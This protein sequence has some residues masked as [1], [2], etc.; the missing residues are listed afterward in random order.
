MFALVTVIAVGNAPV[1]SFVRSIAA[2]LA[3]FALSIAPAFTVTAVPLLATVI[4]PLSPSE[5]IGP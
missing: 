5:T 2:L 4:S 3:I 1:A